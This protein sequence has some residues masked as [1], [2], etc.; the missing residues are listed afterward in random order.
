M[1]EVLLTNIPEDLYRRLLARAAEHGRTVPA[2][3]L[4]C[5]A[6][7][8]QGRRSPEAILAHADRFRARL[9]MPP[10]EDEMINEAKPE[11]RL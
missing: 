6:E 9:R 10:V 4:Q 11:G 5:V 3:V 8:A 7:A 2:E 1:A